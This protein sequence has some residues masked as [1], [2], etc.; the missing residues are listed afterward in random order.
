M[1]V[2][3]MGAL[4]VAGSGLA[5]A[6]PSNQPTNTGTDSTTGTPASAGPP[7]GFQIPSNVGVPKSG[8]WVPPEV[9]SAVSPVPTSQK[10][11]LATFYGKPSPARQAGAPIA[12]AGQEPSTTTQ[13]GAATPDAGLEVECEF[14]LTLYKSYFKGQKWET[15]I[16]CSQYIAALTAHGILFKNGTSVQHSGP[17]VAP[18]NYHDSVDGLWACANSKTNDCHGNTYDVY[19][20][21]TATSPD[22]TFTGGGSV[23]F[24]LGHTET[25][26]ALTAP[27]YSALPSKV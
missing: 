25:C 24:P 21:A 26:D 9:G 10:H 15:S 23:C 18:L 7:A 19:G 22:L 17:K 2:V 4:Q 8:T 3:G 1:G 16:Q 5:G 13:A 20:S 12:D 14:D 11:V 6:A 27:Y